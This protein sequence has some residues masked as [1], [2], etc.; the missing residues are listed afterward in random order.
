LS[1]TQM[2]WALEVRRQYFYAIGELLDNNV[3]SD[4]MVTNRI[5]VKVT[6]ES[7]ICISHCPYV[8]FLK[9]GVDPIRILLTVPFQ[10]VHY[11]LTSYLA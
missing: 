5:F 8:P 10:F 3:P 4:K 11:K 7:V 1:S 2:F 9:M 6:T